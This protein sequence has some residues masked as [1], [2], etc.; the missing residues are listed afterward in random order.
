[1]TT[2]TTGA[3]I[4]GGYG[5]FGKRIATA[6][7]KANIPITI[8]GR[9]TSNQNHPHI[10]QAT[11]DANTELDQQLKKLKPTVVINTIGPFQ[12]S[13]YKIAE[14]CIKHRTHYIDIA[15]G[16][17]FV[18]GIQALDQKAKEANVAIISGASTIPALSSAVIEHHKQ[19]FS[20]ID[21]LTYGISPGQKAERGLATTAGILSYIGRPLK[22]T[23]NSNK[24]R[25]GWQDLY[26]QEYPELGTRWMANCD[27]PDLDLF[28]QRY[29]IKQI[30]FSAGTESTL[31]HLSVWA[32][33]WLVR[34]RP[35]TNL[36][37]HA[38]TLLQI[39]HHFD[40]LGTAD[41]GMHMIIKGTDK[42]QQPHTIK[43][44]IIAKDG[45]GPQIPTIPAIILAKKATNNTLTHTGA[46]PCI[47][48]V[49]LHEY[50]QELQEYNIR[51]YTNHH[52]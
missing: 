21:S 27:I 25:Y 42:N 50:L 14:T 28:P 23:P 37:K 40:T 18:T 32:T 7:A 17:D 6:L 11:F 35:S 41:G 43:W 12:T 39:S 1:M 36:Q 16:R 15:D 45:D 4:L 51:T 2:G 26:R 13:N 48:M 46:T 20:Q 3:L 52:P 22:Q 31:L 30:Q 10:Q 5:N 47:G 8:A 33:S 38:K 9:N 19:H 34:I 29:N 44:F 24:T 49:T